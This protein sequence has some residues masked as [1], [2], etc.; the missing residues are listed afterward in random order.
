MSSKT[1]RDVTQKECPWLE[2]DIKKG[3]LL[4]KYN[5][6]T[7]GCISNNGIAVSREKDIGPFF[8]MPSNSIIIF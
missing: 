1:I 2:E 3:T 5:G 4:H 8:E 7:Y 6:H